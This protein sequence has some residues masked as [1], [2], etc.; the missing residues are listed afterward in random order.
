MNPYTP[1]DVRQALYK[2]CSSSAPG[3]DDIVYVYLKKMPYLHK[4]LDTAFTGIRNK[5]E[6]PEKW[7]MSKI[8]LIK[9][10]INGPNDDLSSFLMISLTLNIGKLFQT[11]EAQRMIKFMVEKG[12]LDP[13]AQKAY[14]EGINGCVEH[15]CVVQEIMQH[16]ILNHETVNITWFDLADAFG[17]ISH[18]LIPFVMNH[19]NIPTKITSYIFNLCSK[20]KGK[21][22][23]K[24]WE[25]NL[26]QF[27]KG[28]F[29]GDPLSRVIF[30]IEFNP[31]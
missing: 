23:C 13:V 2:K 19:Y 26:F 12:Y 7:G 25:T 30:L 9:K 22:V 18:L 27:F 17:S 15:V 28:V 16:A 14:I 4:V 5:G 21:V 1:R 29:Q 6:A 10:D 20:L 8:I 3:E 24:D 11:L 31:I